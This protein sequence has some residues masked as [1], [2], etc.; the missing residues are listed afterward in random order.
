MNF[1]LSIL[2]FTGL[3]VSYVFGIDIKQL[4]GKSEQE[5]YDMAEQY[6]KKFED[7]SA[8][9]IC[10]HIIK[11]VN[12]KNK[13][14]FYIL[15]EILIRNVSAA[16]DKQKVYN[17]VIKYADHIINNIDYYDSRAYYYKGW[18]YYNLGDYATAEFNLKKSIQNNPNYLPAL[19]L[20]VDIYI[21]TKKFD[22]A[23]KISEKIIS[24]GYI[25]NDF[26]KLVLRLYIDSDQISK[27]EDFASKYGAYLNDEEA[28]FLLAKLNYKQGKYNQ[29][30]S[31]IDKTLQRLPNDE[32]YLKLKVKILYA[33]KKYNEAYRMITEKLSNIQ[34]EEIV[35]IKKDIE[36]SFFRKRVTIYGSIL[37]VIVLGIVGY[38]YLRELKNRQAKKSIFDLKKLY[39]QK[40]SV[41]AENLDILINLVYD[42][43]NNYV[44][45]FNSRMAIYVS[46]PRK[47][48]VLYCYLNNVSDD[49]PDVIYIFPKYSGWLSEYSNTPVHLLSLQS[50]NSFYDWIGG[51]NIVLLK[52]NRLNFILS[53]VSR[54]LLQAV[55][56]IQA[57]SEQEEQSI[58][59]VLRKYKEVVVE[60]LE[61]IANDVM[62]TR[63]KEA[64]FLDELTRLY[65]RRFMYQKL[66]QELEKASRN[67]QKLSVILC[68][69]DN[70]K[71][72][73]DTY[74]HQVGDEVLRAVAKVFKG[75]SRE[76]FDWPFR[77]GGEEIGL[78]LPNTSADKA[79]EIAERIRKEVSS[80]TFENVPTVITISLGIATYP[81]HA[82]TIDELIKLADEAL[83]YSKRTGKN[84]TTIYT[85]KLI[86]DFQKTS[87][88]TQNSSEGSDGVNT[89]QKNLDF[90]IPTFV[91]SLD[92][93]E[94]Y[95]TSIK[96]SYMHVIMIIETEISE[97]LHKLVMDIYH[98]LLLVECIG[99]GVDNNK[100]TIKVLLIERK[101][102]DIQHF[103]NDISNK[104][105]VKPS[106]TTKV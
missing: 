51:K 89:Q 103:L 63:F 64:S 6:Y 18:G 28:H 82:K 46:D 58:L 98:N 38:F 11:N 26:A 95:Y 5:L 78:I 88:K 52:R 57:S 53:C 73:N 16:S 69:I 67:N 87:V 76:F 66:E 99:M 40:V 97:I 62:S 33:M 80:R 47:D 43:I 2:I 35:I 29:A 17:E 10:V 50:D 74:G 41:K 79:F 65:N 92:Q 83:Y 60:I 85:N 106:I 34:D 37:L 1:L 84:K 22:E 7:K 39:Q 104:Y 61:E 86:E 93:F 3:I 31:Y 70:F 49:L 90:K 8:Y 55:I 42:F 44:L 23:L 30:L 96:D 81:D 100:V 9:I 27:A 59:Q 48:N 36:D 4:E 19:K 21:S 20:L 15:A 102:E 56:F 32:N 13:K 75:A 94:E 91:Y 45:S 77:Y 12:V 71:K 72:F 25:D 101:E 68:D 105:N 24:K 14:A 54:E